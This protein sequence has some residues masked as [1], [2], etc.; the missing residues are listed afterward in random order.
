MRNI[1][2]FSFWGRLVGLIVV[3]GGLFF[4]IN[5]TDRIVA[6]AQSAPQ[7]PAQ[8][9]ESTQRNNDYLPPRN[10]K[11]SNVAAQ[12]DDEP[13]SRSRSHYYDR[14]RRSYDRRRSHHRRRHGPPNEE[15]YSSNEII[16]AG[17]NFF[18]GVSKGLGKVVEHAFRKQGRPNGYILG[19]EGGGAFVAG[20]RY[21]QGTLYTKRYGVHRVYWQGPS[22]GYDFGAEGSKT[23][24]LVYN[25]DHISQLYHRFA[26]VDG[27][28]YFVGGV[29][30]TFQTYDDVVLA[31]IRSGI[32]IRLGANVGY[33]KY[34]RTPTW[35]PF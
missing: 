2:C 20:L 24:V 18:G 14:D 35:N 30:L 25:L 34:S 15:T 16:D 6:F 7:K 8:L 28:A 23:L 26:G 22:L 5:G 17:H 31:P 1:R 10:G 12:R 13:S 32:G 3:I 29:G 19:E 11:N 27:S 9:A 33:L 21:G 4:A